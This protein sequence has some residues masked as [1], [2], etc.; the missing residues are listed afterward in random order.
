MWALFGAGP[1]EA[2]PSGSVEPDHGT[3]V[4]SAAPPEKKGDS[5]HVLVP[6]RQPETR[7]AAVGR[8]VEAEAASRRQLLWRQ[9]LY[10]QP[11]PL[12]PGCAEGRPQ[13]QQTRADP[14][15]GRPPAKQAQ[16]EEVLAPI[17]QEE[18]TALVKRFA[19]RGGG[20]R[21]ATARPGSGIQH[22]SFAE[23]Q[24]TGR[25]L[26]GDKA[27]GYATQPYHKGHAGYSAR[28]NLGY[29]SPQRQRV[30][31]LTERKQEEARQRLAFER[32]QRERSRIAAQRAAALV[33]ARETEE[34]ER[35]E[36]ARRKLARE[37]QLANERA[38]HAV[39]SARKAG[40]TPLKIGQAMKPPLSEKKKKARK[41]ANRPEWGMGHAGGGRLRCEPKSYHTAPNVPTP[42]MQRV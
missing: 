40:L 17:D 38:Y 15:A 16:Q 34:R 20:G 37:Q 19:A 21:F 12:G 18:R 22:A 32:E 5:A 27:R 9:Q 36:E 10:A 8:L 3:I 25:G 33:L 28:G 24:G 14:D 26:A 7:A 1:P 6:H 2:A 41:R 4:T 35:R 30:Q 29:L 31:A 11:P 39:Q 23:Q 13:Q 42:V